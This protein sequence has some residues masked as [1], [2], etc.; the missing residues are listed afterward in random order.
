MNSAE[1]AARTKALER[2]NEQSPAPTGIRW[3][4]GYSSPPV[5]GPFL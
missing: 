2:G 4:D 5:L 3:N 1:L